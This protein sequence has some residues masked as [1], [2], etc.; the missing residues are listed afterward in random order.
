MGYNPW[1]RKSRTRL[2]GLGTQECYFNSYCCYNFRRSQVRET[3]LA[4]ALSLQV[5]GRRNYEYSHVIWGTT[6]TVIL[7]LIIVDILFKSKIIVTFA[8]IAI[9]IFQQ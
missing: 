4:G 5:G 2:K 7:P 1:G 9:N 6:I 8:L 3:Q